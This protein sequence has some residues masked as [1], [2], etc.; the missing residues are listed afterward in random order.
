M[1]K[2]IICP[3]IDGENAM[4]RTIGRFLNKKDAFEET[5]LT[6]TSKVKTIIANNNL[7]T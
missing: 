5:F 1:G 6:S 2:N 4:Y 7:L 3:Y